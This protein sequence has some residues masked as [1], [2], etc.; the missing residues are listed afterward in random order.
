M[1]V[2]ARIP[3][4]QWR[5]VEHSSNVFVVASVIDEL[6][7][8]S[9]I[10]PLLFLKRLIGDSQHVQ[11]REDFR[12]DASRLMQ[13]V[14]LA[15]R[16]SDWGSPL[17]KGQ[18]R[19]IAATYNQGAWIA[20]VAEVSILDN[21]LRVKRILAVADCG[22]LINPQGARA[23]LEGGIIDGVGAALMGEI[24]VRDG[25]VQQSNFHDYPIC[26]I[27]QTPTIE[28]HFVPGTD[29]PRGLGEPPLPP[30]APAICNAIFAAS[31]QRIRELPLNKVFSV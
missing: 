28:T 14:D 6:A 1:H 16:R 10:D 24:T 26:R 7:H 8:K 12:F 9:S 27:H 29:A 20:E 23:Q 17:P 15:A 25:R 3:L 2:P 22:L 13:V 18:G 11:V 30:V 31:G 4:G 5:A 21:Q 19:G